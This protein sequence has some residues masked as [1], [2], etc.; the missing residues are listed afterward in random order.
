MNSSKL[1]SALSVAVALFGLAAVVTLLSN[2]P[3]L[4]LFG[5]AVGVFV[6]LLAVADYAPRITYRDGSYATE[7]ALRRGYILR[8]AA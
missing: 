1:I 6:M 8:L 7:T 3:A 2:L 4:A 5:G